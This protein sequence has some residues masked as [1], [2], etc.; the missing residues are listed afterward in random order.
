MNITNSIFN[1]QCVYTFMLRRSLLHGLCSPRHVPRFLSTSTGTGTWDQGQ[2]RAQD[3]SITIGDVTV[4]SAPCGSGRLDLVPKLIHVHDN[5]DMPPCHLAHL[6]WMLQKDLALHQDFLLLGPPELA[7]DRR[8]LISLYASL[9]DREVEYMSLSRDTSDADL[10]QRKEVLNMNMKM[11]GS[12][13]GVDV[14]GNGSGSGNGNGTHYVNQA[15]VRAALNGRLLFLDGL[16][17]VERNVLPTLNNLLENRELSL[18]DGSML[19]SS[20]IYD[21]HSSEVDGTCT[22]ASGSSSGSGSGL[23][24]HRVHPDFRVVGS[25]SVGGSGSDSGSLDPPLRSR[26]QARQVKPISVSSML[27]EANA[28]SK[29]LLDTATLKDLVQSAAEFPNCSLHSLHHAVNYVN[30]FDNSISPRKVLGANGVD[31]SST[32]DIDL[33]GVGVED[34]M[35]TLKLNSKFSASTTH[36]NHAISLSDFVE[37][38][39]TNIVSDLVIAGFE[40][41]RRA[42]ALVGPKGCYKSAMAREMAKGRGEN[43]ELFSLYPDMMARDLLMMRGTDIKSGNTV[44]RNSPLMRAVEQGTWVILDGIDK[45]RTDALTSLAMLMEQGWIDLPNGKR[46]HA[47]EGFHC[48]ALA[49]PQSDK[50]QW[51]TPEI[52]AMFSWVKADPL[53]NDELAKVLMRLYPSLDRNVLR[54]VVDL[55]DQLDLAIGEGAADSSDETE[56]LLLTFRKIKHICRRIEENGSVQ[57]SQVV[58]NTMMTD[59]MPDRERRIVIACMLR[60]G[61]RDSKE[62]LKSQEGGSSLDGELLERCRR[63]PSNL[64]L[65]PN[66]QFEEN[67]GHSKVMGDILEAHSVGEKA[68]L[69]TGYQGK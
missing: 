42:V 20:K 55:R 48:I 57:I 28:I 7:S 14:Y 27:D 47:G 65:V 40:S 38:E 69:I 6:R 45:L 9:L 16:E 58:H 62:E 41:G 24:I 8:Y 3:Q 21:M 60:S 61:I 33:V 32:G 30:K 44:W 13:G 4:P 46:V 11:S 67:P 53:P 5:H 23:K 56:S 34:V 15:P 43:I 26:F 17:K 36:T 64:L 25:L 37:T 51:I 18:D 29:G 39:T 10:K 31:I 59:F 35:S 63:I 22:P 49:H 12:D 52:A 1:I 19:V 50:E 66:P 68:L 54:T 2:A